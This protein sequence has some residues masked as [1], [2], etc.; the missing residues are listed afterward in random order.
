MN[1]K[2]AKKVARRLA[3]RAKAR[4]REEA[5][6]R[7]PNGW[8]NK[9]KTTWN[10]KCLEAFF[11]IRPLTEDMDPE[12]HCRV[13]LMVANAAK[14][15]GFSA[16]HVGQFAARLYDQIETLI[17]KARKYDEQTQAMVSGEAEEDNDD[18]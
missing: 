17:V 6:R 9:T 14:A 18:A 13:L 7:T 5:H 3:A 2:I 12:A 8:G 11:K 4:E 1:S 15:A 16:G 10:E